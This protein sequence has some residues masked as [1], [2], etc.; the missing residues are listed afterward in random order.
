MTTTAAAPSAAP[1]TSS[2]APSTSAP[3]ASSAP[4]SSSSAPTSAPSTG[5]STTQESSGGDPGAKNVAQAA[6]PAGDQAKAAAAEAARQ[7]QIR[8]MKLKVNGKEMELGEDEVIRRAQLASAADQKFQEAAQIRKQAEQFIN[9]L[10][11][12][13]MS[14]LTHPELADKIKFRQLAENFLAK[15]LQRELMSPEQRELAELREYRKSQEEA[16]QAAEQQQLTQAQQAERAK[17]QQ[18]AAQEYD[19]K[20]TEILQKSDLPKTPYTVKRVAELLFN[21]VQKG[22]DLDVQTAVDMVREGYM[23]DL[24]ALVG[25]LDGESLIK[26]FGPDLLKKIRK[27]DLAQLKSRVNPT[28]MQASATPAA[29]TAPQRDDAQRALTPD[30][31]REMIRKRAGI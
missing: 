6:A 8:K 14:V 17:L 31:W 30:E 4:S 5:S 24:G 27:Y 19:V 22:Y 29:A 11:S 12:D 21:A 23:S 16:R 26:T 25:G 13:P 28:N 20:M 2:P 9:Q 10:L 7:E 1:S 18:R 3:S 15:E